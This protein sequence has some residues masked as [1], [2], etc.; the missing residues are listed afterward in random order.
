MQKYNLYFKKLIEKKIVYVI[1]I[2]AYFSKT[3]ITIQ[4]T[5]TYYYII[6]KKKLFQFFFRFFTNMEALLEN[7]QENNLGIQYMKLNER[8][9]NLQRDEAISLLPLLD[10]KEN[11]HKYIKF[12]IIDHFQLIGQLIELLKSEDKQYI[13]KALKC[14]WFFRGEYMEI[15]NI[16]FFERNLFP[17]IS[18]TT[19]IQIINNLSKYFQHKTQLGDLFNNINNKYGFNLACRLLPGCENEFIKSVLKDLKM[20]LPSNILFKIAQKDCKLAIYYFELLTETQKRNFKKLYIN[21]Y[22]P[23]LNYIASKNTTLWLNFY[24][25]G[26][27]NPYFK[28]NG[29]ICKTILISS[30]SIVIE[31]AKL[32]HNH[33][34]SKYFIKYL[35]ETNL[36]KYINKFLPSKL[37]EFNFDYMYKYNQYFNFLEFI[38]IMPA[39]KQY[40]LIKRIFK[41][42]YGTDI[43][44][45][46]ENDID[47][48]LDKVFLIL[49]EEERI[50]IAE[51]LIGKY[52]ERKFDLLRY[53]QINKSIVEIKKLLPTAN[54]SER[55]TLISSLVATCF[56]N[57]S[58]DHF[59]EVLEFVEQRYRNDH[60]DIR[61]SFLNTISSFCDINIYTNIHWELIFKFIKIFQIKEDF[62]CS[63]YY[64]DILLK[65]IVYQYKNSESLDEII[66]N[67]IKYMFKDSNYI[68]WTDFDENL[69]LEYIFYKTLLKHLAQNN[70]LDYWHEN[71]IIQF[72]TIIKKHNRKSHKKIKLSDSPWLLQKYYSILEENL[73]SSLL[74]CVSYCDLDVENKKILN[75][76][77]LIK[78][79]IQKTLI[80]FLHRE[81]ER[82]IENLDQ[83]LDYI[84]T[85]KTIKYI[86]FFRIIKAIEF[87]NINNLIREKCSEILSTEDSDNDKKI[88]SIKIICLLS[89][90]LKLK[91]IL[92][93]YYPSESTLSEDEKIDLYNIR[94]SLIKMLFRIQPL[95]SYEVL[96]KFLV[97]DYLNLSLGSL[98][99]I[100]L[101]SVENKVKPFLIENLTS[102]VSLKKHAIKLLFIIGTKNENY[103]HILQLIKK[104][105]NPS[106][107]KIIFNLVF[108]NFTHNP[109]DENYHFLLAIVEQI[110]NE[111]D[112]DNIETLLQITN[113]PKANLS[114]YIPKMWTLLNNKL[115]D[116]NSGKID[117]MKINLLTIVSKYAYLKHLDY[118]F[119]E[120]IIFE[121]LENEKLFSIILDAFI[122]FILIC[123]NETIVN[124]TI[125]KMMKFFKMSF[126][127]DLQKE[128]F[129]D[130]Y[131]YKKHFLKLIEDVC[132]KI[133]KLIKNKDEYNQNSLESLYSIL[134]AEEKSD[135]F[136][137]EQFYLE[138]LNK[139]TKEK[140]IWTLGK[141][142]KVIINK[143]IEK[144]S[145][146]ILSIL[147]KMIN[148]FLNWIETE[149]FETDQKDDNGTNGKILFCSGLLNEND[150]VNL[151]ILAIEILPQEINENNDLYDKY[152][153]IINNLKNSPKINVFLE[154]ILLNTSIK[155]ME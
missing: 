150:S 137:Q 103:E 42:K 18:Y 25:K 148:K 89:D 64:H 6:L 44:T 53:L 130:Q 113:I 21:E 147:S 108:N 30:P 85:K 82:I 121:N 45:V 40:S 43:L 97:N 27:L 66:L 61:G 100:C 138:L 3:L 119:I 16:D 90:N 32:F 91:N 47:L 70:N 143:Y 41:E 124:N 96:T 93:Q 95:I 118:V 152:K 123:S 140:D 12:F 20:K 38:K 11:I 1:E 63:Y 136:F 57:D 8:M 60:L 74:N 36:F 142:S 22:I 127:E 29:E 154:Y 52:P 107:R 105:E 19:K 10:D 23:T 81:P 26:D 68:T 92:E 72:L 109:T 110:N 139:Y 86:K 122:N 126:A 132:S 88:N 76:K 58:L 14:K 145:E 48:N 135:L 28:L 4:I 62:G 59:T 151:E 146:N 35:N 77:L 134:L 49:P 69:N 112:T 73:N 120:K 114:D 7:I 15:G 98:Y 125:E 79:P 17:F 115:I 141:K 71:N 80:Y 9:R 39:E 99:S 144:Y 24:I 84:L 102:R 31:N 55:G 104:E 111:T 155:K 129:K 67:M 153:S 34:E 128:S 37:S 83:I 65:Y 50:K 5:I 56:I 2:K 94:K 117:K 54:S 51:Y 78:H 46:I 116:K 13:A 101:N 133:F 131:K 33:I 87:L 75:E 106:L 149:C